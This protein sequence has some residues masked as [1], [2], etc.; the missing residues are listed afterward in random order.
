MNS[1]ACSNELCQETLVQLQALP[2]NVKSDV[3]SH[4]I[5]DLS[6][7]DFEKI[8]ERRRI[9]EEN[10]RL[11]HYMTS[12]KFRWKKVD[13]TNIKVVSI[14]ASKFLKCKG[15]HT[16]AIDQSFSR[17]YS[18][19][20]GGY[21]L[22]VEGKQ[23]DLSGYYYCGREW[24]YKMDVEYRGWTGCAYSKGKDLEYF[25]LDQSIEI[26]GLGKV[27]RMLAVDLKLESE[28][29][30]E[31]VKG[32]MELLWGRDFSEHR[33]QKK[34]GSYK[35]SALSELVVRDDEIEYRI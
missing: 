21:L 26:R 31:I 18:I 12:D 30:S 25:S 7:D 10:R 1:L 11:L 8:L 3:I 19:S 24:H 23:E 33:V 17:T 34:R 22:K 27:L 9:Q 35:R 29:E 13:L 14:P 15:Q 28:N 16:E 5:S 20:R 4:Y 6:P 32:L 2:T